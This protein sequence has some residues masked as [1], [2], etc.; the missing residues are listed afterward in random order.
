MLGIN[1][2]LW[3]ALKLTF[4]CIFLV[5]LLNDDKVIVVSYIVHKKPTNK[6]IISLHSQLSK[7]EHIFFARGP[8]STHNLIYSSLSNKV[9]HWKQLDLQ[10]QVGVLEAALLYFNFI[11]PKTG[12]YITHRARWI[13]HQCW[14]I[15][16]V[17]VSSIAGN[18]GAIAIAIIHSYS[19]Y[20]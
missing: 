14:W 18:V 11:S 12:N 1:D 7:K 20:T 17:D 8:C 15:D 6:Q 9:H 16:D 2:N 3:Y 10:E 19:Y 5:T 13:F 4:L